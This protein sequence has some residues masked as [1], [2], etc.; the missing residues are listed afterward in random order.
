V[1]KSKPGAAGGEEFGFKANEI[2]ADKSGKIDE[3]LKLPANRAQTLKEPISQAKAKQA[4]DLEKQFDAI[5]ADQIS[6]LSLRG[7]EKGQRRS[8]VG[9]GQF[10]APIFQGGAPQGAPAPPPAIPASPEQEAGRPHSPGTLSLVFDIPK[11][12]HKLVFTKA[13]GDPKLAVEL[14]PRKS[15]ELLLGALWMLPWLFVLL[16]AMLLFS[17]NRYA[18]TAWRQL[19]YGLI[20]LGLLL[21]VFLPA[22]ALWLGLVLV[23]VGTVQASV[24]RQRHAADR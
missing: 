15:L 24:V 5:S 20:A 4:A 13:G 19:P 2:A 22:P 16:L 14:R 23:A 7:A 11:E 9:L 3:G 10:G 6:G 12:G 17:R 18:P 8:T 21:F 1:A